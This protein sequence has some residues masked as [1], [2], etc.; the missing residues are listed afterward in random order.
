[1]YYALSLNTG[2]LAGSIYLNT[3]LMGL[4]EIPANILC[5]FTLN[6]RVTGRR[7][8]CGGG[9]LLAGLSLFLSTPFIVNGTFCVLFTLGYRG[10]LQACSITWPDV[11]NDV[12]ADMGSWATGMS[13]LGKS[14]VT[15]AFCGIYLYSS[16]LL[17]TEVRNGGIGFASMFA[18]FSGM[19]APFIGGP[20][21]SDTVI[22]DLF[23][24]FYVCMYYVLVHCTYDW[25]NQIASQLI[26]LRYITLLK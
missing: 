12:V 5:Y 4:V 25:S 24:C 15:L 21:V 14:F 3:A 13:L 1:M 8:T 19:I 7:V 6:W 16:E 18:R 10:Y 9:L 20:L 11:F 2:S 17:P 22:I 23:I 26:K